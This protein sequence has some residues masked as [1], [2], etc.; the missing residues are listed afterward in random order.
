MTN[1]THRSTPNTTHIYGLYEPDGQGFT[2]HRSQEE[3]DACAEQSIRTYLDE[4]GWSDAVV[5]IFAFTVTH[6]VTATDVI[7]QQGE[8]DENGCDENDEYWTC[9]HDYKC[10]YQLKPLPTEES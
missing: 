5:G 6:Q 1:T 9:E 7:V 8:L 3:R 4:D 10:N 2:F